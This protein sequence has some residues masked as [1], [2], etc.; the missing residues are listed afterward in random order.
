MAAPFRAKA[1]ERAIAAKRKDEESGTESHAQAKRVCSA[2]A[3]QLQ[4]LDGNVEFVK[5]GVKIR[6]PYLSRFFFTL[7]LF[8]AKFPGALGLWELFQGRK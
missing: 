5:D 6:C 3:K 2:Q 4:K 7:C 8:G 1:E